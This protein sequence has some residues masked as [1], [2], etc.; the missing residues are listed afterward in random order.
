MTTTTAAPVSTERDARNRAMRTFAWGLMTD[1]LVVVLPLLL[2][3]LNAYDGAG[4]RQ[5]W[6]TVGVSLGKT[7]LMVAISYVMRKVKPPAVASS[8]SARSL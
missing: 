6:V 2:D 4:G 8:D 5:Y 7:A 3:A 1:V